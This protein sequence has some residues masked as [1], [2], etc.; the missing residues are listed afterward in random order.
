M[1][2]GNIR[3]DEFDVCTGDRTHALLELHGM[4]PYLQRLELRPTLEHLSGHIYEAD[5][6]SDQGAQ[7][8]NVI[9]VPGIVPAHLDVPYRDADRRVAIDVA[10]AHAARGQ[11]VEVGR[12]DHRVA[13]A[14]ERPRVV[15][16][17]H[18]EE[19]VAWF[20]VASPS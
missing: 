6:F 13:A 1:G 17:R 4:R 10:E 15:L 16:F 3:S 7:C 12:S 8:L 5:V 14:A 19:H 11:S 20:H 9:P 18:D 2:N